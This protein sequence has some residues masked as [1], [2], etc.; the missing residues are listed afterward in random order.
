MQAFGLIYEEILT[1]VKNDGLKNFIY[2]NIILLKRGNQD[3]EIIFRKKT[4]KSGNI[5]LRSK[6]FYQ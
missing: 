3:S 1:N 2:L 4:Y 5:S 6:F